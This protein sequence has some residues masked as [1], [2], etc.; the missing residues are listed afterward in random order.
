MMTKST[1][2]SGAGNKI[3]QPGKLIQL[4]ELLLEWSVV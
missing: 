1:W 2:K 4:D 3:D